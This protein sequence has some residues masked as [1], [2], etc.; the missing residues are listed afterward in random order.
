VEANRQRFQIRDVHDTEQ[1]YDENKVGDLKDGL[2]D[3][4]KNATNIRNLKSDETTHRVRLR[5]RGRGARKGE[6]LCSSGARR[7]G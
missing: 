3:A 5:R 6:D 7:A 4:L 1:E 2:F